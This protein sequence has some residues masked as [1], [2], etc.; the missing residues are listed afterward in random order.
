MI[1]RT[2]TVMAMAGS[3]LGPPAQAHSLSW[4]PCR[5]ASDRSCAMNG[6][7]IGRRWR[8]L[9][10]RADRAPVPVKGERVSYSGFDMQVA[11]MPN[12]VHPGPAPGHPRWEQIAKAAKQAEGGDAAGFAEYVKASGSLK[13]PSYTGMNATHCVDGLRFAD[14]REYREVLAIGEKVSPTW[15]CGCPARRRSVTTGRATGST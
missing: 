13:P 11:I 6:T 5:G 2:L 9:I 4:Q 7:D 1:L 15:R 12:L 3:L 8:K 14:Y 10:A